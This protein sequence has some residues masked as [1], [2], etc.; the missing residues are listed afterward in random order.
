MFEPDSP[1]FAETARRIHNLSRDL[2]LFEE[3]KAPTMTEFVDA[4]VLEN[5]CTVD[6]AEPAL[7]GVVT[8]HPLLGDRRIVTSG[9]YLL[10]PTMGYARTLSRW[11]RLG[12]PFA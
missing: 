12:N 9:L 3:L 10:D 8:G 4:P 1:Q 6:R 7:A 5:W 2:R 11:Y